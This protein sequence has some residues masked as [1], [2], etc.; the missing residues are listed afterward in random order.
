[1]TLQVYFNLYHHSGNTACK[2]K[3]RKMVSLKTN[4]G[5][6]KFKHYQ[7][8]IDHIAPDYTEQQL[9]ILST[10]VEFAQ[11]HTLKE[12]LTKGFEMAL[13]LNGLQSDYKAVAAALLY[14][15]NEQD[16]SLKSD[17][18]L[19]DPSILA[20]I[21]GAKKM[22]TCL[23]YH[24]KT[25]IR[26]D[27]VDGI[28]KMLTSM[29]NDVRIV[30]VK[31]AEKL[32]HLRHLNDENK[33]AHRRFAEEALNIYAPLASRLGI[34][35]L[36][37]E[38]EDRAFA[39][40]HPTEYQQIANQIKQTRADRE[41]YIQ[42]IIK[43][44]SL[45]LSRSNIDAKVVGRAK[46][47]YSIWRKMEQK[48][49]HFDALF[50]LNAVRILVNSIDECY[51]VLG[52]VQERYPNILNEYTDYI[53][54]PKINGYQ[55]IHAVLMGPN[56]S[57]IEVQIRTHA[58]NEISEKGIAAHWRYKEGVTHNVSDETKI[59]WLRSLLEWQT[60]L[61][62]QSESFQ[63][64]ARQAVKEQVY[65]STPNGDVLDFPLGA[66]PLDFAYRIHS[67]IGHRCNGAKVLGKMVPLTY[68][69]KTGD[70][71]EILTS[72]SGTPSRDWLRSETK[73]LATDRAKSKVAHWFRQQNKAKNTLQ[74][75][76]IFMKALKKLNLKTVDYDA[77][78]KP[79]SLVH[80]DDFFAGIATG[81]VRINQVIRALTEKNE[82][83]S[84]QTNDV[85]PSKPTNIHTQ[86]SSE[87]I[88][89]ASEPNLLSHMAR[90]CMPVYGDQVIG[91]IT[92]GR[93]VSIHRQDCR[94]VAHFKH[95]LP[96]RLVSASWGTS[97][98]DY[99]ASI[100]IIAHDHAG[101]LKELTA[102]IANEQ[103][104]IHALN[105]T[106]NPKR[107]QT[108]IKLT[109]LVQSISELSHVTTLI[110]NQPFVV[111]VRRTD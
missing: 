80:I 107:Q 67:Q 18:N 87:G 96:E 100:T 101:I 44:I 29:I 33:L 49:L 71:V 8:F 50:D 63:K 70:H 39:I 28:R 57:K 92:T 65:V 69:L 102:L 30:L 43:D 103:I 56:D 47:I 1:M 46:H 75:K 27:Q 91:F 42:N 79:Y 66:T 52:I 2:A 104:K 82:D 22:E 26:Q 106:P 37:W 72:K 90:C 20:I 31:L 14:P 109:L 9:Q 36:K 21:V 77:I 35:Q 13:I 41:H 6:D 10:A 58:M 94:Y 3:D 34:A 7:D 60:N 59:N 16:V 38:L 19:I 97:L 93:G 64:A 95:Q 48:Q 24:P 81:D 62:E 32:Y 53:A 85:I 73:Y 74:G 51:T 54:T 76:E 98:R 110:K 89:I 61:G 45:S 108:I 84:T 78:M 15:L 25:Q 105:S 17:D 68:A 11:K 55:S 86:E 40:Q 12:S 111:D 4:I 23:N 5:I 83:I 88:I 99:H